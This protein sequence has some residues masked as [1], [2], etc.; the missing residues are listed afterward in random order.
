MDIGHNTI[1]HFCSVIDR[2][3]TIFWNGPAGVSELDP[4]AT[5][6]KRILEAITNATRNGAIT[7]CGG[8]LTLRLIR[9]T[10]GAKESISHITA[11]S[12]IS[13]DL[14]EGQVLSG[15]T[16]LSQAHEFI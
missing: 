4:F 7:G 16:H 8:A 1:E 3:Q 2:S 5:G 6:S 9:K 13:L 15:I 10:E 12:H 11:S 14:L